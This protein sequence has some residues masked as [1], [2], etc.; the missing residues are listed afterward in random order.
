MNN[1]V[2][3]HCR[4]FNK[5]TVQRDR[6]KYHR[7]SSRSLMDEWFEDENDG[8]E[9]PGMVEPKELETPSIS[10]NVYKRSFTNKQE[11]NMPENAIGIACPHAV[12]EPGVDAKQCVLNHQLYGNV[13]QE[14]M[15]LSPVTHYHLNWV[16]DL[17]TYATCQNAIVPE[18]SAVAFDILSGEVFHEITLHIDVDSQVALGREVSAS[19][20]SFWLMQSEEA[21]RKMLLADP[22]YCRKRGIELPMPICGAMSKLYQEIIDVSA[23][24]A[25]QTGFS[26]EPLVWGN[27]I[28]FDLG[29]T[30]SLFETA[31]VPL[32]WQFW[33]ERDARTI[34]DLAPEIKKQFSLD[35]RG[36]PHYGLD[37]CKHELRYLS[38]TYIKI[39]EMSKEK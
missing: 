28:T 32:P 7:P 11:I 26:K 5:A 34:M 16:F 20:L 8:F 15:E 10:D 19:T 2:A 31:Q 37:D 1:F 17:E 18:I 9:H 39:W 6:T 36:V 22:D 14:L 30:I 25:E 27:G 12:G 38:A 4:T 23:K 21:R 3:K 33:A 29:K 13:N 35:F 24:W